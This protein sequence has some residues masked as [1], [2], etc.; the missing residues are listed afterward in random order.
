MQEVPK[1]PRTTSKA[2]QASLVPVKVKV[3][4]STT[5]KRRAKM[6]SLKAKTTSEPKNKKIKNKPHKKAGLIFGNKKKKNK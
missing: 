2:P 5:R 4:D 1:E 6:A 3:H